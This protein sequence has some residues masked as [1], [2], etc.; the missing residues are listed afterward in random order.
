MQPDNPIVGGTVLRRPAIQSPNYVAGSTGWTINAD[1]SVE[2]NN[3]AIRG[4]LDVGVSPNPRFQFTST[5]P[6][7]LSTWGAA[8]NVTFNAVNLFYWNATNF[9]FA[10]VGIFAGQNCFFHGSY[11]TVNGVYILDRLLNNGANNLE[12]RFGSYTLN[13][14]QELWTTQQILVQIG[15]GSQINDLLKVNCDLQIL[16]NLIKLVG[17]SA[18]TWHTP[19]LLNSFSQNTP[20][21]QYR[22]IASPPN[23]VQ[24][25][26]VVTSGTTVTSGTSIAQLPAGYRPATNTL[27]HQVLN[28]GAGTGLWLGLQADGNLALHGTWTNGAVIDV[29]ALY[30]IDK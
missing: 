7:V 15:D 29:A 2:F 4:E 27:P 25:Y 5:I 11:D 28:A 23:T 6:T 19:T 13:A 24:V 1:G 16:G 30:P 12:T 9:I 14:F 10:A 17:G 21:L 20:T 8:N 26:G 3:A 18:E 22:L